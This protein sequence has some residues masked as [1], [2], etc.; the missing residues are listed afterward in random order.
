MGLIS[1]TSGYSNLKLRIFTSNQGKNTS[2]EGHNSGPI[3]L[4][5]RLNQAK[6]GVTVLIDWLWSPKRNCAVM[7]ADTEEYV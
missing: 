7:N 3:K 5:W 6:K 4:G 1:Y 2:M